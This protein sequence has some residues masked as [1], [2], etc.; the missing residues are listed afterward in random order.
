MI[1]KIIQSLQKA[2]GHKIQILLIYFAQLVLAIFV[3]YKVY[4][5]LEQGIGQSLS[6]DKIIKDFDYTVFADLSIQYK[7]NAT[8]INKALLMVIPIYMIVAIFL[9][10]GL[11]GSIVHKEYS[12]KAFFKHAKKYY[13]PSLVIAII[14]IIIS[15]LFTVAIWMPT[16][17]SFP[18]VIET[19]VSDRLFVCVISALGVLYLLILYFL[20]NWSALS[21]IQFMQ[22][23][24]GIFRS[25]SK[26]FGLSFRKFWSLQL[27]AFMFFVFAIALV[28]TSILSE[29]LLGGTTFVT[30]LIIFIIQ[31]LISYAKIYLRCGYYYGVK[32]NYSNF[33]KGS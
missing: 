33:I 25:L 31:Q 5:F 19:F 26:G 22:S 21:R 13:F 20:Q 8:E 28:W 32:N 1:K 24:D 16:I 11:L 23:D 10:S 18:N 17:G 3:G 7:S 15:L 12:T 9:Q 2:W 4:H 6:L 30:I 14:I 29:R 27:L